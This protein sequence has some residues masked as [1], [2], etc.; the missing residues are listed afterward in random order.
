MFTDFFHNNHY[1]KG[2]KRGSP[3][4]ETEMKKK[5]K[6]NNIFFYVQIVV[7]NP[8]TNQFLLD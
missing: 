2:N 3:L 7:K 6:V 8:L 5:T 4:T 1:I